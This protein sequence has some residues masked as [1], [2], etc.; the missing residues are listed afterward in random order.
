MPIPASARAR[1]R[2]EC[3]DH[4]VSRR[5][6][7]QAGHDGI[8]PHAVRALDVGQLAT[9]DVDGSHRQSVE[10]QQY[11]DDEVG[12]HVER[13]R[14]R[15]NNAASADQ[16]D[17]AGRYPRSRRNGCER[18]REQP[19]TRHGKRDSRNGDRARVKRTE[20]AQHEAAGH[21]CGS[22]G[23]EQ[24]HEHLAGHRRRLR[25]A[26]DLMRAEHVE[27]PG[28]GQQVECNQDQAAADEGARQASVRAT[29]LPL[30]RK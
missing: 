28:V 26:C 21:E 24:A 25:D 16:Q 13:A 9:Q 17:R 27:I 19:V 10:E 2:N 15:K 22:A 23:P 8:A 20:R 6:E 29:S 1:R 7:I 11:E 30:P 5:G 3:V 12:D 4:Q 14:K 18:P